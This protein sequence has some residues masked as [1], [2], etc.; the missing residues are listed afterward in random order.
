MASDPDAAQDLADMA[1]LAG[2]MES[3]LSDLMARHAGRLHAYLLRLLQNPADAEDLAQETFVRVYEHRRRFNPRHG[4]T[5]WMYAIATNL[6]RDRHRWRSRHP[7][8][9]LD[10]TESGPPPDAGT[11]SGPFLSAMP[12]PLT[13]PPDAGAMAA[14]RAEAV[15]RAIAA[16]PPD[17]RAPL[18]LA[19]YEGC[20]HAEIGA[21]LN[22]TP[23]AVEMRLYRAR[24]RLRED[25]A[26][27]L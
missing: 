17:L 15:R 13:P 12:D 27:W 4:F 19:E 14:E 18:L 20:A 24:Q 23:K 26:D 11:R 16:L 1:R 25:L 5:S 21:A 6:A 7:E 2:D 10:S 8:T 9:S 3:A 22:L